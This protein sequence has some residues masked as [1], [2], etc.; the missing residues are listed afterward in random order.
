MYVCMYVCMYV[1]FST[2]NF[3]STTT[4]TT[5]TIT[6]NHWQ[7]LAAEALRSLIIS[8]KHED[9]TDDDLL[10]DPIYSLVDRAYHKVLTYRR[11][12]SL[13]RDKLVKDSKVHATERAKD[14]FKGYVTS[15]T[16]RYVVLILML[17]LIVMTWLSYPIEWEPMPVWSSSIVSDNIQY[18]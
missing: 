9:I 3:T 7:Q 4:A 6:D 14:G 2:S 1:S 15:R 13:A 5:L 16:I 17:M 11:R 10:L 12:F 8:H 18:H